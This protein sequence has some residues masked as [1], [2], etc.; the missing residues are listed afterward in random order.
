MLYYYKGS[1]VSVYGKGEVAPEKL[2]VMKKDA[3]R[4]MGL[5]PAMRL[6]WA[7]QKVEG[8][9]YLTPPPEGDSTRE[10]AERIL[11]LESPVIEI[12]AGYPL[13]VSM[14]ELEPV[15]GYS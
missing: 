11:A 14:S 1:V 15:K 9:E 6:T 2:Q 4:I 13:V 3:E 12:W 10:Y 5:R 8:T 7:G